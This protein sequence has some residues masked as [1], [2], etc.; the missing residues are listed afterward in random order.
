MLWIYAMSNRM[1]PP[2]DAVGGDLPS[3]EL[4]PTID[5]GVRGRL[6]QLLPRTSDYFG[7]GILN[8]R[9]MNVSSATNIPSTPNPA[10]NDRADGVRVTAVVS[11]GPV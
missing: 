9:L 1:V 5:V 11:A 8:T 2:H 6:S 7:S 10:M 4:A 3:H